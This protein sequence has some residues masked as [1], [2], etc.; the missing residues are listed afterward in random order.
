MSASSVWRARSR[1]RE[2]QIVTV[3]FACSSSSAIGLPTIVAAADH[4]RVRAVELDLVL[5][6]AA[7]SRRAASPETSVGRPR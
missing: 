3:A 4:D 2:W 1:V 7:P 6:R 5:A